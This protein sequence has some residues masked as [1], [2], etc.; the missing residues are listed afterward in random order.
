MTQKELGQQR[1]VSSVRDVAVLHIIW[2]QPAGLKLL[3][4]CAYNY[5]SY[6]LCH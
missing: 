2:K 4:L 1:S 3:D 5:H 6:I